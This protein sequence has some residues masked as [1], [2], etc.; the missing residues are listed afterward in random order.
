[1]WGNQEAPPN[2]IYKGRTSEY[3]KKQKWDKK[4][5]G[6]KKTQMNW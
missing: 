2:P 1:M 5:G 6:K 3:I 4:Y